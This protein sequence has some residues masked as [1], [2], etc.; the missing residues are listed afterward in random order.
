V[1]SY[2]K[3]LALYIFLIL[4]GLS[5]VGYIFD[6][7]NYRLK[8][9]HALDKNNVKAELFSQLPQTLIAGSS[10]VK[11]GF[12]VADPKLQAITGP[13]YN[14]GIV[15]VR[16]A[17]MVENINSATAKG[18]FKTI[19][20]GLDLYQF[21]TEGSKKN[22]EKNT[23]NSPTISQ[24]IDVIILSESILALAR[25]I[26]NKLYDSSLAEDKLYTIKHRLKKL[27]HRSLSQNAEFLV[28]KQLLTDNWQDYDLHME[29][30]DSFLTKN[31]KNNLEIKLFISPVHAR[32]IALFQTDKKFEHFLQWKKDLARITDSKIKS[33][34]KISL[35]DFSQISEIT[36]EEFPAENDRKTQMHYYWESS[37]Y[38]PELGLLVLKYLWNDTSAA[39]NFGKNLTVKNVD[40]ETAKERAQLKKYLKLNPN[41]SA[42]FIKKS[43]SN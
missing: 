28:H 37:H 7:L 5:C 6:P 14:L 12:D 19:V 21:S 13:S 23:D 43:P 33:G 35:T 20:I 10:R 17:E 8:S 1:T 9:I 18:S 22:T 29:M 32:Q 39:K 41:L 4:L 36:S 38:K 31:C 40:F 30:F 27:G 42:E 16:L 34:C 15:G 3:Y 11:W 25:K 2:L 26:S 24:K